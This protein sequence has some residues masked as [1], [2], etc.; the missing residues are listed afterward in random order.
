MTRG[1]PVG[2][3]TRGGC[4]RLIGLS[5]IPGMNERGSAGFTRLTSHN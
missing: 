4:I 5:P 2:K 1:L 3:G